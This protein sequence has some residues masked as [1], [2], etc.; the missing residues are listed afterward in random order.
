MVGDDAALAGYNLAGLFAR[1]GKESGAEVLFVDAAGELSSAFLSKVT[2]VTPDD[3]IFSPR[4]NDV[5]KFVARDRHSGLSVMAFPEEYECSPHN[6]VKQVRDVFDLVIVACG[7]GGYSD[8]WLAEAETVVAAGEESSGIA[9]AAERAEALRGHNGTLVATL[10]EVSLTPEV[11]SRPVFPLAAR[12]DPEFSDPAEAGRFA[13]LDSPEIGHGF[14]PL[15]ER[16]LSGAQ[17]AAEIRVPVGIGALDTD[18]EESEPP[19]KEHQDEAQT[20]RK[21]H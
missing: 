20:E 9:E 19:D 5:R 16:M 12:T 14:V 11:M 17:E 1:A 7:W 21:E 15:A 13:A 2:G 10:G 18:E 4:T 6:L 8:G 3:V